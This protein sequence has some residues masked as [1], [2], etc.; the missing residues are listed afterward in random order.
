MAH[1]SGLLNEFNVH[2]QGHNSVITDLHYKINILKSSLAVA[3]QKMK[4]VEV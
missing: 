2:L 1:K 3:L 4:V